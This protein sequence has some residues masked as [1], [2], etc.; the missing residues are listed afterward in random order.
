M[1]KQITIRLAEVDCP[2][3]G[4]PFSKNAKQ[5]TSDKVFGKIIS[6]EVTDIDRYGRTIAKVFYD[7]FYLSRELIRN[8]L[9]WWYYHYST[10]KSLGQ[11]QKE[12]QQQKKGLFS[13]K[14]HIAPWAY[15]QAKRSKV[16][17][18]L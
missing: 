15:R 8:G 17:D 12:A 13:D 18:N 3:D 16:Y 6:Y 2:E 7:D 9:G 11:L 5:F 14:H 4:Q 1:N 10:D